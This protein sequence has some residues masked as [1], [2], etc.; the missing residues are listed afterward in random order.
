MFCPV[1]KKRVDHKSGQSASDLPNDPANDLA[2][3]L[4]SINQII[5]RSVNL[6]FNGRQPR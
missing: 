5:L 4:R 2:S 3:D 1:R 6:K